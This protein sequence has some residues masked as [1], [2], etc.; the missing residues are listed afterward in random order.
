MPE[1]KLADAEALSRRNPI[2]YE[3]P[4]SRERQDLEDHCWVELGFLDEAGSMERLIVQVNERE[5]G[6]DIFYGKLGQVPQ[7][8]KSISIGDSIQ[9]SAKNVF[10]IVSGE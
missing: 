4:S 5:G 9:F 3:I 1:Y 6:E 8:V 10:H 7:L 2:R